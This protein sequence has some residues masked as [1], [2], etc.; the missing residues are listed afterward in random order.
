MGYGE[1]GSPPKIPGGATLIFE[2]RCG[3]LRPDAS[4]PR[5]SRALLRARTLTPA[6]HVTQVELMSI[7][8]PPDKA[9]L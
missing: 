8:A 5:T 2:A 7:G 3:A 6:C 4:S 9:E 1:R